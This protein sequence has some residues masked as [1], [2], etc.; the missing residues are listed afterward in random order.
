MSQPTA[1][2]YR[3]LK[4]V[5]EVADEIT[6]GRFGHVC[7]SDGLGGKRLRQLADDMVKK[8]E[9]RKSLPLCHA[10]RVLPTRNNEPL[11]V[12]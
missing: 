9:A 3:D 6:A 2:E 7:M 12:T 1:E 4:I 5:A 11:S 8:E 10:Q